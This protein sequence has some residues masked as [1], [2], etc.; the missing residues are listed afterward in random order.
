[1]PKPETAVAAA[2]IPNPRA[3]KERI[4]L[5]GDVP[6]PMAPPSGCHFHTRCPFAFP[7]CRTAAPVLRDAGGGRRFSCHLDP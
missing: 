3:K 2:P 6:S 1:M 4:V 5:E 7:G